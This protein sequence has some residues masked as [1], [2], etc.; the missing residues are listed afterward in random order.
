MTAQEENDQNAPF[1]SIEKAIADIRDG[2][3]VIVTDDAIYWANYY[4]SQAMGLAK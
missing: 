3:M 2:K 1:D 4:G